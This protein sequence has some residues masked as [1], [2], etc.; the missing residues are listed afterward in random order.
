MSINYSVWGAPETWLYGATA[1]EGKIGA[2][3]RQTFR[4]LWLN[5]YLPLNS[6]DMPYFWGV[7]KGSILNQGHYIAPYGDF[8]SENS[9]QYVETEAFEQ[10]DRAFALRGNEDSNYG[11]AM[12]NNRYLL[13]YSPYRTSVITNYQ[14]AYLDYLF[15][16]F[17]YQKIVLIPWVDYC[18][19]YDVSPGSTNM[20]QP[21]RK[22]VPLKKFID[23][24]L[25][26][27]NVII[28]IMYT[29]ALRE[30]GNRRIPTN[31]MNIAPTIDYNID[32]KDWQYNNETFYAGS[33]IGIING[34]CSFSSEAYCEL[35]SQSG[36]Y[37]NVS[38][39]YSVNETN[40]LAFRYCKDNI[41]ATCAIYYYDKTKSFW[42]IHTSNRY[43]WCVFPYIDMTADNVNEVRDYI[44]S[45]FAYI[46]LLF[47]YDPDDYNKAPGDTGLYVPVFDANGI[48]TGT[49]K[50]GADALTLSNASWNVPETNYD[51]T[52]PPEPGPGP[53]GRILFTG[54]NPPTTTREIVRIK[55]N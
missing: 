49:Y 38:K 47:V 31:D 27:S 40:A 21:E 34:S 53:G 9:A 32:G 4:D 29:Y 7:G 36:Y 15:L 19:R 50:D 20:G 52:R 37:E 2:S 12:T 42:K 44:L 1:M 46:G 30:A 43:R 48:T 26:E 10:R 39:D 54:D 11:T 5:N 8:D 41:N 3:G 23:D 24:R 6:V 13:R 55:I 25:Y 14:S 17:N 28:R 33:G 18:S 35:T 51:P 45:Q 22:G 16:S